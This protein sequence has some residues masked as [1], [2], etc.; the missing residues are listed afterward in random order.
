MK[1]DSFF[2]R[3]AAINMKTLHF[4][5]VASRSNLISL[6]SCVYDIDEKSFTSTSTDRELKRKCSILVGKFVVEL[7]ERKKKIINKT[8]QNM[9]AKTTQTNAQAINH[10][11]VMTTL[12][13]NC[14]AA[15]N[16]KIWR[17][18]QP[19]NKFKS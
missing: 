2:P 15:I 4:F 12:R 14:I 17:P 6:P 11:T 16:G 7:N 8:D 13:T 18:I 3:I 9:N 10:K 5:T 19:R 1:I